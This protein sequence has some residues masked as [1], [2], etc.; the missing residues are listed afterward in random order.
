MA[1]YY[2][3]KNHGRQAHVSTHHTDMKKKMLEMLY[4][5]VKVIYK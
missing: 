1:I 4:L 2:D 5:Y 3:S